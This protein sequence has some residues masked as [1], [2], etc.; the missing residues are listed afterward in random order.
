MYLLLSLSNL[1]GSALYFSKISA[2][3]LS[4]PTLAALNNG[5]QLEVVSGVSTGTPSFNKN[6]MQ[7]KFP[8]S[9]K[10]FGIITQK[11]INIEEKN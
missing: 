3:S 8:P 10:F 7:S 4:P 5:V 11:I 1:F 2:T 6:R 9:D